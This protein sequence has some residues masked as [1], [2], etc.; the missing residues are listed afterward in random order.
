MNIIRLRDSKTSNQQQT[1]HSLTYFT[2]ALKFFI[3]AVITSKEK[4]TIDTQGETLYHHQQ[5]CGLKLRLRQ[6]L[7]RTRK[8]AQLI[9][10]TEKK[11][12]VIN[13][14]THGFVTNKAKKK[15]TICK[16]NFTK[17]KYFFFF[18]FRSYLYASHG[19]GK[20]Q[21]APDLASPQYCRSQPINKKILRSHNKKQDRK[22]ICKLSSCNFT[23]TYPCNLSSILAS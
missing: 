17:L 23:L 11:S 7:K 18:F 12:N 6:Q 5:N 20:Q 19:H 10:H 9:H 3:I 15:S 8:I 22:L 2:N 16:Y 13:S 1:R 4:G 21:Q 14:K